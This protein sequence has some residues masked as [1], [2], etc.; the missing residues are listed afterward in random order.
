MSRSTPARLFEHRLVLPAGLASASLISSSTTCVREF[1][2]TWTYTIPASVYRRPTDKPLDEGE[3]FVGEE[4]TNYFPETTP[5]ENFWDVEDDYDVEEEEGEGS[6]ERM[7]DVLMAMDSDHR[8][9]STN[10]DENLMST[11]TSV[12]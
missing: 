7:A 10:E 3:M 11:S 5:S 6:E 12:S 2:S 4:Y 8:R 9:K 1:P